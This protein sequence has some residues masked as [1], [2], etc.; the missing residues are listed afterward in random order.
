MKGYLWFLRSYGLRKLIR[1]EWD[2]VVRRRTIDYGQIFNA[3]ERA[4]LEEHGLS[5]W[6]KRIRKKR[7]P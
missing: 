7:W 1:Y 5:V 4:I 2:R 3:D 6:G